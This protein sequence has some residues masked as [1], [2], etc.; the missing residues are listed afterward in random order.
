[1]MRAG[2]S[3]RDVALL[4]GRAVAGGYLA[5]HGAQ[6]L[7]GS[8][9]GP[10]LARLAVGFERLGLRP[11]HPMATVAG[12]SEFGGGLLTATGALSPLGPLVIAGTMA[13]A[14][15]THVPN[16]PFSAKG[17]YELALTNLGAALVLAA[18]GPGR[19]SIDGLTGRSLP[20]SLTPIMTLGGAVAAAAM[21][22][23]VVRQRRATLAAARPAATSSDPQ[24]PA[25]GDG[26]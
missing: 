25:R 4:A 21:V 10:G 8:F 26:N 22:S 7:F 5:A 20:P 14:T 6:K 16:G 9:G 17:G 3:A 13:V 2:M 18:A 24:E 19:F 11:G 15:S 12:L 1:M 23:M